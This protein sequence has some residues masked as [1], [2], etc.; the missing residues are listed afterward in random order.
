MTTSQHFQFLN[1][2]PQI[3]NQLRN[4][5]QT[6]FNSHLETIKSHSNKNSFSL[7]FEVWTNVEQM[8]FLNV[9]I[10]FIPQQQNDQRLKQ[11]LFKTVCISDSIN[12]NIFEGINM[13]KCSGAVTNYEEDIINNF[14][15]A[16]GKSYVFLNICKIDSTIF[17]RNSHCPV[18]C[19]SD[20]GV[21]SI[22]L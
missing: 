18:L 15:T 12:L 13:T 14:C 20:T 7:G 1:I 6:T 2:P 10:N 5:Y 21:S 8:K 22:S 16:H 3:E 9:Y 11:F 19:N 4:S 17:S